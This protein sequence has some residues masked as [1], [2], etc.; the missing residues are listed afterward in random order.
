L[1][2]IHI[3][4][5][6]WST[7]HKKYFPVFHNKLNYCKNTIGYSVTEIVSPSPLHN[8][9]RGNGHIYTCMFIRQTGFEYDLGISPFNLCERKYT[10]SGFC[11]HIC[12]YTLY[13]PLFH[14]EALVPDRIAIPT[15]VI[16]FF[17]CKR[18]PLH[19]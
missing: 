1:V 12:T 14:N 15:Q 13:I 10:L 4:H 11:V 16:V 9:A 7:Q 8:G 3:I 18:V 5:Y 17:N 2:I 19:K 6:A